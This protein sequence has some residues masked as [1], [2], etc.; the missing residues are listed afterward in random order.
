MSFTGSAMSGAASLSPAEALAQ[1]VS[2]LEEQ[3]DALDAALAAGA[4]DALDAASTGL[5]QALTETLRAAGQPDLGALD[6][7]LQR[8]LMNARTRVQG[9]GANVQRAASSFERTLQVLLPREQADTYGALGTSP[10]AQALKA[11]R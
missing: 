6:P 3:L 7:V 10:A 5:Q 4:P 1:R 8:R 11:Y 2:L 9:L